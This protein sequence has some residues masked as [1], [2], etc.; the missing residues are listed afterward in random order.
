MPLNEEKA[1]ERGTQILSEVL[2]FY[3]VVFFLMQYEIRKA[4]ASA[5][6]M[7]KNMSDFHNDAEANQEMLKEYQ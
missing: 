1:F 7:K 3:F 2:F 6:K 4:I 5:K